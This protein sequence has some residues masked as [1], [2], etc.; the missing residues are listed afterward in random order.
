MAKMKRVLLVALTVIMLVAIIPETVLAASPEQKFKAIK[1]SDLPTYDTPLPTNG[2][3]KT[4]KQ[5]NAEIKK[6]KA[7]KLPG[8]GKTTYQSWLRFSTVNGVYDDAKK[9]KIWFSINKK[10]KFS[11]WREEST[12]LLPPDQVATYCQLSKE[13]KKYFHN[14]SWKKGAK[15]GSYSKWKKTKGG[16][17]DSGTTTYSDFQQY[18]DE[19]V[20]GQK[21][22]VYSYVSTTTY[23]DPGDTYSYTSY[24]WISRKNKRIVKMVNVSSW[25][26]TYYD[27]DTDED[28]TVTYDYSN[29]QI[30]FTLKKISKKASF[31]KKPVGVKFVSEGISSVKNNTPLS[32]D[33]RSP[34][35]DK[36]VIGF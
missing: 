9:D 24:I 29:T 12:V 23:P 33:Y 4:E 11:S 1:A 36:A 3:A 28:I 18:K 19:T 21:C 30:L 27:W 34:L 10:T 6:I 25:T 5:I 13:D 17:G 26:D 22:L 20:L 2:V 8:K 14:Y 16:G 15:R 32:N 7:A 35:V 31:F